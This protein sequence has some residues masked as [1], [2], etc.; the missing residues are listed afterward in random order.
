MGVLNRKLIKIEYSSRNGAMF[1]L[2]TVF[3][4]NL[5]MRADLEVYTRR[6]LRRVGGTKLTFMMTACFFNV[7]TISNFMFILE[8]KKPLFS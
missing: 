6:G 8:L 2:K 1:T 5:A 7:T 3:V 4:Y